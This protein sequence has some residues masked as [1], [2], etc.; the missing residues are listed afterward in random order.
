MPLLASAQIRERVV[1]S[2][3]F[4]DDFFLLEAH[5]LR[6]IYVT[7]GNPHLAYACGV[8]VAAFGRESLI[9]GSIGLALIES[10]LAEML[11]SGGSSPE[12]MLLAEER[13]VAARGQL[14]KSRHTVMVSKALGEWYM[15]MSICYKA[16]GGPYEE[17]LREAMDDTWMATRAAPGD[18]VPVARQ[19]V[20]RRQN[21]QGH[22]DLLDD[23]A[24]YKDD[25][26][27]EYYRTVKRVVEFLTN[28]GMSESVAGLEKEFVAAFLRVS[29]RTTLVGQ[30]SFAKNL[31][32]VSALKGADDAARHI[33]RQVR[34]KA[35][36]AGLHGQ[37]RQ[38]DSI[39]RA[40]E[41]GDVRGA[42]RTFRV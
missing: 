12:D 9:E 1:S 4:A 5:R 27:M 35:A 36:N 24:A 20:M 31:A 23:A 40:V 2:L 19:E 42:L 3:E 38:L 34:G 13:L 41:Q 16:R 22:L 15:L 32:Q 10:A 29:G 39:A 8:A 14:E 37:V 30:I 25:R 28:R 17:I 11:I 7:T 33:L 6:R 26:P 21:L 18:R